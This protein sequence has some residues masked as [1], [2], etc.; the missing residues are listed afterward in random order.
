MGYFDSAKNRVLWAKE[1]EGLKIL[2]TRFEETGIDPFSSGA[3]GYTARSGKRI[4][5]TFRELERE[6]AEAK[7]AGSGRVRPSPEMTPGEP[8]LL[9]PEPG[10]VR[11]GGPS[12]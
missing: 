3:P 9:P 4:P 12:R 6:E 8:A 1:L 7:R 5:V 10:A 2:R 11:R